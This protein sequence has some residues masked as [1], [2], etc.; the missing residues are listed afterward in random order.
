MRTDTVVISAAAGWL[1]PR[2]EAPAEAGVAPEDAGYTALAVSDGPS[3]PEMAVLAAT[4]AL[5]RAGWS[6][7]DLDLVLHA[8]SYYQG[9]DFWSP[10]HYLADQLGARDAQPFGIQQMCNGGA[11]ALQTAAA[12]LL[13]DP[14]VGRVL[15]TTADRFC[16]PGFDRWNSDLGVAYGDGASALLVSRATTAPA[17]TDVVDVRPSAAGAA[18]VGGAD[19]GVAGEL[20]LVAVSS[21]SAPS[22][23]GMHRGTDDFSP[24]ARLAAPAVDVRR[25]KK[26]YLRRH[27]SSGYRVAE[28]EGIRALLA[29]ALDEAG[30]SRD[31]E[32]P[33]C[34][35]LPR[36][37]R[38]PLE[39]VF[40][41]V[42]EEVT[43]AEPIDFGRA[44]GHL[45]AGDLTTGIADLID[46]KILA[47]GETAL[48]L[49][50][51]AGF[52]WS[53]A[54]LTAPAC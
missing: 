44:T 12:H 50:T 39:S 21:V 11:A 26:A 30:L 41:P 38:A 28:R 47:P 29:L 19:A 18:D 15:V 45:G 48:V 32:R 49:S 37:H 52:T 43:G 9:H 42:V 31:G 51:G 2:R 10:A 46:N 13:A 16:P 22:L 5:E 8:W 24:A 40:A 14:A 36:V 25:T 54:T 7:A 3:A 1:P 27:G 34:V 23:E 53:C 35:V 33:R 6:G 17:G 4:A 20:R